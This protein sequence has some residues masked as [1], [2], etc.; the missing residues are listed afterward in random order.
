[1]MTHQTV[2]V[3]GHDTISGSH[4]DVVAQDGSLEGRWDVCEGLRDRVK[5]V[6]QRGL[7]VLGVM[8]RAE[9]RPVVER[10]DTFGFGLKLPVESK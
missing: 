7:C 1:M 5:Q 3:L 9:E 8:A 6:K 2:N 10:L 4:T